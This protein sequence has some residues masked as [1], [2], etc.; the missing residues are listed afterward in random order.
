MLQ[1]SAEMLIQSIFC[2]SILSSG[3]VLLWH[4]CVQNHG[5]T[6]SSRKLQPT[7]WSAVLNNIIL[8]DEDTI[9][10]FYIKVLTSS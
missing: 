5:S 3:T 1:C 9:N 4:Y 7:M 8:I 10:D 2:F 6:D